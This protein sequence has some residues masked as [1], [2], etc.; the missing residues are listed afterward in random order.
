M[1]SSETYTRIRGEIMSE[2]KVGYAEGIDRTEA[3]LQMIDAILVIVDTKITE[4]ERRVDELE[5]N[6]AWKGPNG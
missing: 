4:L 5:A 2:D 6:Q 1:K 3:R